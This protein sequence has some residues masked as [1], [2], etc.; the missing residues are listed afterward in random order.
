MTSG[1]IPKISTRD[2]ESWCYAREVVMLLGPEGL[3]EELL[4]TER[5][6][7]LAEDEGCASWCRHPEPG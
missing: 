1:S 7:F 2:R 3:R 4:V 5:L 6:I